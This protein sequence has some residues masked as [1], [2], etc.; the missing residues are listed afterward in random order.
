MITEIPQDNNNPHKKGGYEL[1]MIFETEQIKEL[2]ALL[3]DLKKE[4]GVSDIRE[5]NVDILHE[6]FKTFIENKLVNQLGMINYPSLSRRPE[7]ALKELSI[8][9]EKPDIKLFLY[10]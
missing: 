7:E 4:F 1:K 6:R 8:F 9:D 10:E 2:E 3:E 5:I